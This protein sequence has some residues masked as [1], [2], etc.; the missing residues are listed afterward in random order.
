M[1]FSQKLSQDHYVEPETYWNSSF[2][3]SGIL[4][5]GENINETRGYCDRSDL[6]QD[7]PAQCHAVKIYSPI[8]EEI[9]DIEDGHKSKL[10]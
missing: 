6:V 8:V 3:A 7:E 2:D 10:L 5:S 4:E 1:F 9:S